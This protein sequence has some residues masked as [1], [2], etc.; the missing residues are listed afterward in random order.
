[1]IDIYSI[2]LYYISFDQKP[3]LEKMLREKGFTNIN[4]FKAFNGKELDLDLIKNNKIISIRSYNDIKN[5]RE[6]KAG[7]PSLGAVGCAMSHYL[8]WKKCID[9]N[10]DYITIVEDDVYFSNNFSDEDLQFIDKVLSQA[11]SA[12]FG[13]KIYKDINIIEMIG[14]QFYTISKGACEELVKDMFPIDVQVD[15]YVSHL[16]TTGKI[17][18]DGKPLANQ[19]MHKSSI[20]DFCVK[21]LLPKGNNFYIGLGLI[22]LAIIILIVYF[23]YLF[24]K[25]KLRK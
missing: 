7:M 4:Y 10:M 9:E 25:C 23:W 2:P 13:S 11:K 18:V 21:C 17:N 3:E 14:M 24:V 19:R 15:F 20:Q 16:N 12:F 5:F 1:M 22:S 6:Q 8:L